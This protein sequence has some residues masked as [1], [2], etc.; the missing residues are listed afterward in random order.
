M[1]EVMGEE[2]LE[3]ERDTDEEHPAMPMIMAILPN[4]SH[5]KAGHVWNAYMTLGSSS[6]ARQYA[7]LKSAKAIK[8]LMR[9]PTPDQ[10]NCGN[11]PFFGGYLLCQ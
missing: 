10:L 5:L 9:L 11:H 4:L 8:T 2:Q 7:R 1:T 3:A 6:S